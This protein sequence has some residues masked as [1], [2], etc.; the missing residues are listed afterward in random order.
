LKYY[1]YELW[2]AQLF[3]AKG[4]K[5]NAF[6]NYLQALAKARDLKE[7]IQTKIS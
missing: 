6:N 7:K 5:I 4:N 3:L 2:Y 1:T